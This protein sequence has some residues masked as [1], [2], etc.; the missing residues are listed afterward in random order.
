MRVLKTLILLLLAS[1]GVCEAQMYEGR[2]LVTATLIAD[3]DGIVPGREITV[4]LR[5]EMEPGW[6]TYWEYAGDAGIPTTIAWTLPAGFRAGAIEWPVPERISDPGGIDI[7]GTRE[8][9]CCRSPSRCRR[10]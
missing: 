10:T 7:Y 3:A 1:A 5:L 6:N 2:E 4:G 8:L 9:C